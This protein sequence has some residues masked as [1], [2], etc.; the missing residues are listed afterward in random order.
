MGTG[1]GGLPGTDLPSGDGVVEVEPF[2]AGAVL[3]DV[4]LAA[5]EPDLSS[6][7]TSR[8]AMTDT[9]RSITS[10]ATM[11]VAAQ[12]TA[13]EA[14][15]TTSHSP[16]ANSRGRATPLGCLVRG[17]FGVKDILNLRFHRRGQ[18]GGSAHV[19]DP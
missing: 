8:W 4:G 9:G 1:A 2:V 16:A 6:L 19:G 14:T 5:D 12:T 17:P 3:I 18:G 11:D 13:V 7:T 15:V 10:A